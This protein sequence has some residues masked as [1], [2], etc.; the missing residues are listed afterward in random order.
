MENRKKKNRKLLLHFTLAVSLVVTIWLTADNNLSQNQV[1]IVELEENK[2]IKEIEVLKK[3]PIKAKK[4]SAIDIASRIE[5]KDNSKLIISNQITAADK[6]KELRS[7]FDVTDPNQVKN[8]QK[9]LGVEQDGMFGPKTEAAYKE[10]IYV[11]SQKI[12]LEKPENCIEC[13]KKDSKKTNP[14]SVEKP[15]RSFTNLNAEISNEKNAVLD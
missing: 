13:D 4:K 11:Q 1:N 6:I 9:I 5:K 7:N 3:T 10:A 14:K 2:D 15:V 8:L 12:A